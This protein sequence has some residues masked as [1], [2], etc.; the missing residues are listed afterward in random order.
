MTRLA[1]LM[2]LVLA[3]SCGGREAGN[4]GTTTATSCTFGGAAYPPGTSYWCNLGD[5]LCSCNEGSF[6]IVHCGTVSTSVSGG[7]ATGYAPGAET[8]DTAA[9]GALDAAIAEDATRDGPATTT[10]GSGD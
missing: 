6:A 2:G 9:H 10:D 5:C 7:T 1:A 3:A 4:V 8:P